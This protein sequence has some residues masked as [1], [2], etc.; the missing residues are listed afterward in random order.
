MTA[1]T[2]EQLMISLVKESEKIGVARKFFIYP[3]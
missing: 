2:D 1:R 3:T